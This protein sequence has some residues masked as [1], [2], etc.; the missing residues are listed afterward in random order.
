MKLLIPSASLFSLP[1][2][3]QGFP[4]TSLTPISLLLVV[5][6]HWGCNLWLLPWGPL[7]ASSLCL[8]WAVFC[9]CLLRGHSC[10]SV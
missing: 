3:S 1:K 5:W 7:L 9:F 10:K 6:I 8:L 2:L 4:L